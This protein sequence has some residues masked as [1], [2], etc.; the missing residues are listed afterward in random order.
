MNDSDVETMPGLW[1]AASVLGW[2]ARARARL[3]Q[4]GAGDRDGGSGSGRS[5]E[6]S[7]PGLLRVLVVFLFTWPLLGQAQWFD[8][9]WAFRKSV[10]LQASQ[11][12][13]DLNDFPVLI[14]VVDPDLA[15]NAQTEGQ[16]IV[17]ALPDGRQLDHEIERFVAATGELIAWVR[18]P[19]VS[20]TDDTDL[21]MY[22]G[23]P[24]AADQQNAQQV[25]NAGYRMVHHLQEVGGNNTDLFD[26]TANATDGTVAGTV[27]NHPT[28]VEDGVIDGAREHPGSPSPGNAPRPELRFPHNAALNITGP[29][30]AEAWAF[31]EPD[32]PIPNHNPV[33]WKGRQIGWGANYLFRIAVKT[34]TGTM[35]WGVTCGGTEGWFE[36]GV[37]VF[38]Q[39][40]HY[41][42]TFDGTRSRAYINGIEQP[43]VANA[44]GAAA[45]SGQ[46]LNTF[47]DEPVRSG[48]TPNREFIGQEAF[49]RGRTD[50]LRISATNRSAAWLRT[51]F[52][53]QSS[54]PTFHLFGAEQTLMPPSMVISKVSMVLSDPVNGTNNP[55]RI[56]GAVL[57][58]DI[59][60]ANEG[61]GVPDAGSI[62]ITDALPDG[63]S[64]VLPADEDAVTLV[65]GTPPS[66]LTLDFDTDVAFSN[67]PNGAP[68]FD[69]DPVD[70]G[71]GV[72]PAVTAIQVTPSGQMAGDAGSGS[73]SFRLRFRV[74]VD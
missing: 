24:A 23:N 4:M 70:D 2:A 15:A 27:G 17:F 5:R 29:I 3:Q 57:R 69:Y 63:L 47:P 20:E 66:N 60:V 18:M 32:Q 56:P 26:A 55:K 40:A 31:I 30:T 61:M 67:Q 16:D 59:L 52:N 14:S 10:A 54:P 74:R 44:G 28:F 46:S 37:P 7:R 9:D 22:Y 68:P 51:Q 58:Y 8:S 13:S 41:A 42:L 34:D 49:L 72:D 12:E 19:F 65:E 11:V 62:V 71:S 48:Y 38:G 64:L 39:W 73:P 35:T 33:L 1:P 43:P 53:N 50:E 45:C 25:W 21:F 36:A 6:Q